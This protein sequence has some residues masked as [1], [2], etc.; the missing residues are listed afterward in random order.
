MVYG[1]L[2]A[3]V[4]LVKKAVFLD[5]GDE[6]GF[7]LALDFGL[8]LLD[9][10]LMLFAKILAFLEG[11]PNLLRL[12]AKGLLS[13]LAEIALF[14]DQILEIIK[15]VH[16]DMEQG[17]GSACI[18]GVLLHEEDVG[19]NLVVFKTS[20]LHLLKVPLLLVDLEEEDQAEN[21]LPKHLLRPFFSRHQVLHRIDSSVQ[22]LV[23][24][25]L[26]RSARKV[27]MTSGLD[28]RGSQLSSS[29]SISI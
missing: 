14:L 10:L 22:T 17:N 29:F 9:R 13:K 4:K 18:F 15:F 27:F 7:N 26:P 1:L 3:P 16:N 2:L 5:K 19:S 11:L 25:K 28:S 8:P 21:G 6:V 20:S 12:F 23:N 24:L